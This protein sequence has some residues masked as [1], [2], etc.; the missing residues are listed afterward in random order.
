MISGPD[1]DNIDIVSKCDGL[2]SFEDEIRERG[3]GA[4]LRCSSED[5]APVQG[6]RLQRSCEQAEK[7]RSCCR[8]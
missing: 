8:P 2:G 6:H 4:D 5:A 3:R 7:T 1:L